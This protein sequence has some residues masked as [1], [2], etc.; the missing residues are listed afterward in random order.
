MSLRH[1]DRCGKEHASADS[2]V[3]FEK[4]DAYFEIPASER[5]RRIFVNSDI[6]DIDRGRFFARGVLQIP[7]H[8]HENFGWGIWVEMASADFNR[9]ITLYESPNQ[10]NEPPLHGRIATAIP[11]YDKPS[12]DIPV[13]VQLTGPTTRPIFFVEAGV[14]HPIAEEQRN[15][16][17]ADRLNDFFAS[18]D[19]QSSSSA[20]R[21]TQAPGTLHC[22]IHGIQQETF[23]CQ[24]IAQGMVTKTRVGFFWT[25]QDPNNPRPDAWCEACEERVRATGEEWVG[26]AEVQLAPKLLCGACYDLAKRFYMGEDLG[27]RCLQCPADR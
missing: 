26:D 22:D 15:G 10:G 3:A 20:R 25:M 4:P 8:G 9:Y 11:A 5:E 27:H 7:V 14:D 13:A 12:L 23:V 1:C 6:C 2:Q 24:H 19:S 16:I 18:I 21:E 17:S